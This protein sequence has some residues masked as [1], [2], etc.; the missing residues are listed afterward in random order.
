MSDD[1]DGVENWSGNGEVHE[2][3][4]ESGSVIFSLGVMDPH[5]KL[6]F[7]VVLLANGRFLEEVVTW[8]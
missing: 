3:V 4:D 2:V 8:K 7:E 1:V 6:V 5:D